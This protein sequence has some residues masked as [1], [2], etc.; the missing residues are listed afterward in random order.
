MTFFESLLK[1]IIYLDSK[2]VFAYK[3]VLQIEHRVFSIVCKYPFI[4]IF[5]K[6]GFFAPDYVIQ[7]QPDNKILIMHTLYIEDCR[8]NPK[9]KVNILFYEEK[10]VMDWLNYIVLWVFFLKTK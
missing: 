4:E 2:L 9:C 8:M 6:L 7:K 1:G 5:L 3:Y 10:M